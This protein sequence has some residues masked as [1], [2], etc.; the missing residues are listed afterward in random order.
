[1][2]HPHADIR[3]KE[4]REAEHHVRR[5]GYKA[6][7][8]IEGDEKQD[9]AMVKSGVRQHESHLHKG[10]PETDLHLKA[11]G[12]VKGKAPKMRAD[13]RARGGRLPRRDDGGPVSSQQNE[14]NPAWEKQNQ[15]NIDALNTP[16]AS[17]QNQ[18]QPQKRPDYARGGKVRGGP[19]K[20]NIVIATGG[21]E[22]ERQMAF[23]QG[24]QTG[25]AV[26][27]AQ[28]KPPMMPP[29]GAMAPPPGMPPGGPMPPPGAIGPMAGGMPPGMLPRPPMKRGGKVTE[30]GGAGGG[31]GRLEKAGMADEINVREHTRRRS[32]GRI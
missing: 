15:T 19:D 23:K 26:G 18:A 31:E 16:Q 9:A 25:A 17:H 1:M 7:G 11:G 14:M 22:G 30:W 28:S 32:G 5:A 12:K 13:K 21:G 8:R 27:G 24:L 6:G 10:E 4:Q 20:V 29:P 3:A 2:V